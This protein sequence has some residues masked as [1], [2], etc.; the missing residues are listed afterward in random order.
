M[1][2]GP[3]GETSDRCMSYSFREQLA[4]GQE[5]EARLDRYWQSRFS[6]TPATMEQQ[7]TGIDRIFTTRAGN[8]IT[9]EYKADFKSHETG[10]AFVETVSV[11][12]YNDDNE[13]TVE[14]HGWAVTSQA[15]WLMY[16]VVATGVLYITKPYIIRANMGNWETACRSVTV[17]NSGYQGR[18]LLVPLK[19]FGSKCIKV[20]ELED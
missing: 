10:N 5:Q 2:A 3:E 12:R 18:G 19:E 6:I 16:L 7:R 4:I 13:W 1:V 20:I 17:K 8:V 11:G 9:V 14:K 15:E